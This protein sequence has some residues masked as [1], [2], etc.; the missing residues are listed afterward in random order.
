M[1]LSGMW[2]G[3]VVGVGQSKAESG[4]VRWDVY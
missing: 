1:K 2:M 4:A 3:M